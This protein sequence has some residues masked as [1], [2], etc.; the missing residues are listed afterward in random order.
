MIK[1][2]PST[3]RGATDE[4]L[5]LLDD[6][7]PMS[8]AEMSRLTGR[9]GERISASVRLLRSRG[10]IYI[11]R[12]DRQEN[13]GGRMI[14]VHAVGS[15][16]DVAQPVQATPKERNAKYRVRHGVALRARARVRRGTTPNFWSGLL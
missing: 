13:K 3:G 7:G 15:D 6:V 10:A 9:K 5:A 14:P 16:E 12:Y 8:V 11:V 4:L 1:I 2:C